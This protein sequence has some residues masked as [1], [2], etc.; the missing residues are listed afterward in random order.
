[1][2]RFIREGASKRDAALLAGVQPETLSRWLA[3]HEELD[4]EMAWAEAANRHRTIKQLY[5][6]GK[7][8]W[9]P[10]SWLLERIH[11]QQYGQRTGLLI[12]GG[13]VVIQVLG[14]GYVPPKLSYD[15]LKAITGKVVE[16][17]TPTVPK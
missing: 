14:G 10:L 15:K 17:E 2:A 9:Q 7:K 16:N 5:K 13:G 4:Q 11:P 12:G 1:M 8:N 3:K 6:H